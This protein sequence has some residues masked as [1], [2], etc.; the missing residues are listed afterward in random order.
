[1]R[2]ATWNVNSLGA[3][4]PRVVEWL[5]ATRPDILCLQETKLADA[6]FPHEQLGELGYE[7]AV[8]GSGQWN[9]VAVVSKVGV[10]D[11]RR[12]FD[13]EPGFPE[14]EARALAATCGGVRVWSLYVPNGRTV[15]SP[16]F[17]YKLAW[18]GVLR[19]AIAADAATSPAMAVCG[20]FN[21]APADVDV[22]DPPAFVGSTHVT[23]LERAA[24]SSL[25]D[26]GF[27]DV[28]A[29]ALKGDRPF[30]YWDYRAGNFHKGM[31]MRIDLV[32]LSTALAAGVTDAYVDRDARKGKLPSDHAP[33]VVDLA[34]PTT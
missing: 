32:L 24:V 2:L 30:T 23:P 11:V 18:L 21:V 20:D 14:A 34:A 31:G 1:M 27:V 15:D 26:I 9:G 4:L 25:V 17:A 19:D 16:H 28:E 3:R 29:R 13:G 7:A 5:A 10:A 6:A 22:W 8:H 12:G 33:V